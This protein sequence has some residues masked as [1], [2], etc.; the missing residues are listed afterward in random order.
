MNRE[1]VYDE[2]I[3]PLMA[4]IIQI[5]KENDIPMVASFQINDDRP[6]GAAFLCTTVILNQEPPPANKLL[7]ASSIIQRGR[8]P[9]VTMLTVRDADG[10]VTAIEAI[11]G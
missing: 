8:E 4:Q 7:E 10:K 9:K 11:V 3:S 1:A 2:K 5:C 6:D